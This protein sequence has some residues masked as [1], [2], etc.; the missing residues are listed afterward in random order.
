MG[1]FRK[2]RLKKIVSLLAAALTQFSAHGGIS[3][4]SAADKDLTRTTKELGQ[5]VT[6]FQADDPKEVQQVLYLL[7][8]I[9]G[10]VDQTL[11]EDAKLNWGEKLT[12]RGITGMSQKDR[13]KQAKEIKRYV[14]Q[15][16]TA[17]KTLAELD[18]KME[19]VDRQEQRVLSLT[20]FHRIVKDMK[21]Q[22]SIFKKLKKNYFLDLAHA[23]AHIQKHITTQFELFVNAVVR[24]QDEEASNTAAKLVS[25]SDLPHS[26]INS[27]T[28]KLRRQ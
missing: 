22:E 1:L 3:E 12:V 26:L 15:L 18:E 11:H 19:E 6:T 17:L 7:E 23:E 24:M 13:I 10:Q 20:E 25:E 2:R 21:A 27:L 5:I 4:L 28:R 9:P 14:Q 16:T 8:K